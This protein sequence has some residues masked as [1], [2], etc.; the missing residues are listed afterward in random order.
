MIDGGILEQT[1]SLIE[2]SR[3]EQA[4]LGAPFGNRSVES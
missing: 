1:A 4:V 3:L 2:D